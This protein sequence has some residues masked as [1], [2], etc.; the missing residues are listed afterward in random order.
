M[1][2]NRRNIQTEQEMPV[3]LKIS[4]ASY[5]VPTP[6][7]AIRMSRELLSTAAQVMNLTHI[8]RIGLLH[9]TPQ[10]IGVPPRLT[11]TVRDTDCSTMRTRNQR[12]LSPCQSYYASSCS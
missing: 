3:S 4:Q 12:Q 11:Q 10:V 2:R 6:P 8:L 1:I 9:I 5:F 7:C